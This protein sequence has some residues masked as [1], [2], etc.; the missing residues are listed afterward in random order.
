VDINAALALAGFDDRAML[1]AA[2]AAI[3]DERPVDA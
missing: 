1:D 3:S 2:L